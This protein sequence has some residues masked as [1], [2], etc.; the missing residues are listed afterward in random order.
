M[1]EETGRDNG[2]KGAEGR[3]DVGRFI[4]ALDR[5]FEKNDAAA[6]RSCLQYWEDEARRLHDERGLLTVLNEQVGFTRRAR[7]KEAALR[8]VD[9]VLALLESLSLGRTVS[10][11]VMFLNAATTLAS[12]GEEERALPLYE[13]ASGSLIGQGKT[14]TYEYAALLNNRASVLY[15]LGRLDEAEEDWLRAI[16]ILKAIPERSGERAISVAML[17]QVAAERDGDREKADA[18]LDEAWELLN[19]PAIRRDGNYAFLLGKCAPSFDNLGRTEE[20]QALRDV[21]DEIYRA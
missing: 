9:E 14:Q 7:E 12:F 11:G 8:A 15:A 18:L 17:A 13:Q 16:G 4:A 1:P 2:R 6:A 20:A 3:I 19:S 10:G 21:A 5:C